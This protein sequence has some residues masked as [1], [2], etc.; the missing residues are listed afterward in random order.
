MSINLALC[1]GV[2]PEMAMWA[3]IIRLEVDNAF[4]RNGLQLVRAN[5]T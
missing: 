2:E 4:T 3:V 5:E 1:M